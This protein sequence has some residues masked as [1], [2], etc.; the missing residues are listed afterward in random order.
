[1]YLHHEFW[2]TLVGSGGHW[3]E[4][5]QC[6]DIFTL[7]NIFLQWI[8]KKICKTKQTGGMK[9][10]TAC[11][12]EEIAVATTLVPYPVVKTLELIWRLGTRRWN[13]RV[14]NLLMSCS[15]LISMIGHCDSSTSNS[16]QG[17]MFYFRLRGGMAPGGVIFHENV[18]FLF[19]AQKCQVIHAF[20]KIHNYIMAGHAI[21]VV[22][23]INLLFYHGNVVI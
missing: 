22:M 3:N 16:H 6:P 1:M 21:V 18:T 13:L 17:D 15:D 5:Q 14:P 11:H 8:L 23:D 9:I 2:Y 7:S 10:N 12:P 20:H 19:V 4:S